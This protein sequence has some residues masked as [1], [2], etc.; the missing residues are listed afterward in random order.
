MIT[1]SRTADSVYF[2]IAT[3]LHAP[4]YGYT[5]WWITKGLMI[6]H[7]PT[8]GSVRWWIKQKRPLPSGSSQSRG[9]PIFNTFS[10]TLP[11]SIHTTILQYMWDKMTL[12]LDECHWAQ[13]GRART[14]RPDWVPFPARLS[15][16]LVWVFTETGGV[17]HESSFWCST[18]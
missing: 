7:N 9:P 15:A 8:G 4:I 16:L 3:S 17:R 10:H 18:C 1:P 5:P 6:L 11:H 13:W 12:W 14:L 2:Y